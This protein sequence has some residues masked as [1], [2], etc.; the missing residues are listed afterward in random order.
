MLHVR[1][2]PIRL[3]RAQALY[4]SPSGDTGC[5]VVQSRI[6]PGNGLLVRRIESDILLESAYQNLLVVDTISRADHRRALTEWIPR[7]PDARS[8]VSFWDI[9]NIL[10]PW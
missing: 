2:A 3:N 5:W 9:N 8:K 1:R 4:G 6:C 10:A 7:H